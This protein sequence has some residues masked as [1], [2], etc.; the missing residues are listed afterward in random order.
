MTEEPVQPNWIHVRGYP[1]AYEADLDVEMLLSE[2]IR[3][4][5]YNYHVSGYEPE[6]TQLEP[7]VE[8][9]PDDVERAN[10]A[11]EDVHGPTDH[12]EVERLHK[13]FIRQMMIYVPLGIV[14][15]CIFLWLVAQMMMWIRGRYHPLH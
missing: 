15:L 9:H 10:A 13:K 6:S 11:L 12:G 2:G 7:G 3:A 4:R 14:G 5:G 1:N 8:V